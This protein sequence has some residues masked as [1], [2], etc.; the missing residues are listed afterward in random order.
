M[1][2][3]SKDGFNNT[4]SYSNVKRKWTGYCIVQLVKSG[5]SLA[6]SADFGVFP[7]LHEHMKSLL[8]DECSL[9]QFASEIQVV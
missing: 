3:K 5:L 9:L 4:K 7:F 2:I 6:C 8:A 1:G